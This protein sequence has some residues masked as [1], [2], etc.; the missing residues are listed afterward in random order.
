MTT[1]RDRL[2]TK[3]RIASAG[4]V[5]AAG[6]ATGLITVAAAHASAAGTTAT[7]NSDTGSGTSAGSNS[8]GSGGG[9]HSQ[10]PPVAST[11]SS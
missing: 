1:P 2:V 4:L 5:L 3:A 11:H 9:S 10:R 7:T 6:G 8:S